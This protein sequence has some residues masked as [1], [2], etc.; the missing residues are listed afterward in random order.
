MSE[1]T[2]IDYSTGDH[3]ERPDTVVITITG[4]GM[5]MTNEEHRHFLDILIKV[6]AAEMYAKANNIDH[7]EIVFQDGN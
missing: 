1:K 3:I 2:R 7:K 5:K 4:T 6:I